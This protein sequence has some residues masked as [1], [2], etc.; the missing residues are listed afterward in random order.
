MEES[1]IRL[2]ASKLICN[3]SASIPRNQVS[4][5]LSNRSEAFNLQN[6]PFSLPFPDPHRP[7]SWRIQRSTEMLSPGPS[8]C[9]TTFIPMR[10]FQS[11]RILYFIQVSPNEKH[12]IFSTNAPLDPEPSRIVFHHNVRVLRR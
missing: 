8:A 4:K 12:S 2:P 1:A 5:A 6:L 11:R 10:N 7:P 9:N 3:V